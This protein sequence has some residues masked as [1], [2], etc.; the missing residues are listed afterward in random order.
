MSRYDVVEQLHLCVAQLE[1]ELNALQQQMLNLRLLAARVFELPGV[2]KGKEHDPLTQIAVTQLTGQPALVRALSHYGRLFMQHQSEK[3]ST[4]AAV[5]LPGAIC[6]E[7]GNAQSALLRQQTVAINQLKQRLEQLITVESG[8]PSEERFEFVHTHLR[9]LI[10]LN[11][12]R[13]IVLVDDADS[14]RFGWANK[15][16]IKKV[17][18]EEMLEKL[19]KSQQSGRA[20]APWTREQW[21]ERVA[22][23]IATLKSLPPGAALKIK[24]PVK[25]QPVARIWHAQQQKQ[26]QLACPSPLLVICPDANS[27]PKLGELG[28]Y[29]AGKVTHRYKPDAQSLHLIIPR[30]HLYSDRLA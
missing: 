5:R 16:I 14:V 25:V 20:V 11:A 12:Y 7:A 27:V 15:H 4:K 28:H 6:L 21:A 10:T 26:I 8:L 18:V 9:G 2:E 30:L 1:Q 23:E 17:S 13:T 29:D 19:Q 3:L 24:R 22:D